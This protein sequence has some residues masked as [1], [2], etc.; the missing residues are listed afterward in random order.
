FPYSLSCA[1]NSNNIFLIGNTQS[2]DFPVTPN[3]IQ[4]TFGGGSSDIFISKISSDGT[5][6]LASTYLGGNATEG[7]DVYAPIAAVNKSPSVLRFN[8]VDH[9]VWF[10]STSTSTN[11]PVTV[12]ALQSTYTQNGP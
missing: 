5:Q 3:A 11:F 12:N 2:L 1:N 8:Q 7:V 9:S 10:T 6:L 4:P